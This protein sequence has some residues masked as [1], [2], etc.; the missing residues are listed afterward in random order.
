MALLDDTALCQILQFVREPR[1]RL[2]CRSWAAYLYT[3]L[4][5]EHRIRFHSHVHRRGVVSYRHSSTRYQD[6]DFEESLQYHFVFHP[7]RQYEMNWVRL[8]AFSSDN[9]AQTGSW[10]VMG[11]IVR[12]ETLHVK[13]HADGEADARQGQAFNIPVADVMSESTHAC[14]QSSLLWEYGARGM[15]TPEHEA[16]PHVATPAASAA[17]FAHRITAGAYRELE[18]REDHFVEVDGDLHRVSD[19]IREKWP[20][21]DW[22][23]VMSCRVRFGMH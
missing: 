23:R 22:E 8:S 17:P 4:S 16:V 20:Q 21:A 14:E 11:D 5:L 18:T 15:P 12:C 10:E 7:T 2:C 6:T 19:D 3:S 9:E 1:G 13:G